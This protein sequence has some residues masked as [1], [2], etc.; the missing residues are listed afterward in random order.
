M[1]PLCCESK[2]ENSRRQ[3]RNTYGS[4]DDKY[5]A[6]RSMSAAMLGE[7][8]CLVLRN[9]GTMNRHQVEHSSR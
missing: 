1:Q 8:D 2:S 7:Y 3:E 4:A 5:L 9:L 6:A